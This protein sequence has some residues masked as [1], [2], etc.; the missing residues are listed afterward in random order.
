MMKVL[1]L[2]LSLMFTSALAASCEVILAV[3]GAELHATLQAPEGVVRPPIVLIIAGSGP[4]D[5]DG[6]NPLGVTVGS[7]R[8]LADALEGRR[9][10]HAA[11]RQTPD[12]GQPGQRS[13]RSRAQV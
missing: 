7:Y 12:R 4:T 10:R 9:Y 3:P 8:K 2:P 11:P 13:Q 6:N 1:M 5:R